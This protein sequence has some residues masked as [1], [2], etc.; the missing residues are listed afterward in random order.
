V[1]LS[2]GVQVTPANV[3]CG[4]EGEGRLRA[5]RCIG[6]LRPRDYSEMHLGRAFLAPRGASADE[7][8]EMHTRPGP[9]L[10]AP[11]KF[12][13]PAPCLDKEVSHHYLHLQR[14]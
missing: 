5:F 6:R 9:S 2:A 11:L 7:C 8:S 1:A 13:S 4:I 3:N 10:N 14:R 12:V